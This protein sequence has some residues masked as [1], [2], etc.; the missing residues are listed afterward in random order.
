MLALHCDE[1][2]VSDN[3]TMLCHNISYGTG[4][5]GADVLSHVK[6]VSKTSDKLLRSTYKHFLT[7]QEIDDMISGKE[8]YLD[9]DEIQERLDTREDLRQEEF[10]ESMD[11]LLQQ[12]YTLQDMGVDKTGQPMKRLIPPCPEFEGNPLDY[13]LGKAKVPTKAV[14][15]PTK[16]KPKKG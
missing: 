7:T 13:A 16:A 2:E 10:S 8:I 14:K 11:S 1:T 4:G 5:K 3:A 9:A 6:H 15:A 12:G